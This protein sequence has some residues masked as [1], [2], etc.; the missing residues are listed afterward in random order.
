MEPY[1]PL[2][3]DNIGKHLAEKLVSQTVHPL[4][5]SAFRGDGVYA[6]YYCGALEAYRPISVKKGCETPDVPPIY[7]G[8]SIQGGRKGLTDATEP[9]KL[10]QRLCQHSKSIGSATT[11]LRLEDFECRYLV[12][13]P[14]WIPLAEQLLITRYRPLWNVVVDGFGNHAPGAGRAAGAKPDWDVVH[15][16]RKWADTLRETTSADAIWLRVKTALS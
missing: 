16:G 3:Y 11:T 9:R 4:P 1:D 6:I 5:P 10:F 14:I 15:P 8:S 2:R 13:V 12:L 7:V